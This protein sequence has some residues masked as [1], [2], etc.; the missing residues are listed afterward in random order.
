MERLFLV[1]IGKIISTLK[2]IFV[3]KCHA[4]F[5]KS[6]FCNL[7]TGIEFYIS[8]PFY[9]DWMVSSIVL[10]KIALGTIQLKLN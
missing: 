3:G 8:N 10:P 7:L 9:F 2:T 6:P 5:P 1:E 4:N